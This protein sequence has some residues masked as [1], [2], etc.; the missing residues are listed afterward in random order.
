[1]RFFIY[2]NIYINII[3]LILLALLVNISKKKSCY[4]YTF[5]I[6]FLPLLL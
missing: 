3:F 6:L 1:M 2:N 5:L 4:I